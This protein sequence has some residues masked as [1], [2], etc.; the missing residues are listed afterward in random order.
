MPILCQAFVALGDGTKN[1]NGAGGT[2]EVTVEVGSQTVEP[3][4]QE[5]EVSAGQTRAAFVS[6]PFTVPPNQ[7]AIIKLQSPNAGDSDVDVTAYLYDVWPLVTASGVGE[8]SIEQI[9]GTALPAESVAGRDAAALGAFLDVAT[10]LL[11]CAAAMRGTDGANT[12]VPDAAGTAAALHATTDAALA[13]VDGLIDTLVARLTAARALLMDNLSNLDRSISTAES[14]IRGSDSDDL[15]DLSD[16]MDNLAGGG[17]TPTTSAL[18]ITISQNDVELTGR[19]QNFYPGEAF[20]FTVYCVVDDVA[21][22][23]TGDTLTITVKSAKSDLDAA[24]LIQKT[25]DV[26]TYGAS[27]YGVF[28]FTTTD[29]DLTPGDVYVDIF[30]ERAAGSKRV[31]YDSPVRILTRVSDA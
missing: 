15:K 10:P 6:Q 25:A 13:V 16:Q 4:P 29:T 2:F 1:L 28:S 8:V 9:L 23:I 12:T 19:L 18:G 31:A 7:A 3:D 26:T 22:D 24:A 5:I 14:N 20:D 27:G 11:T 30:W 21:Q 17:T